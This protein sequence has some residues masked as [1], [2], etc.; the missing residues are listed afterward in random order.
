MNDCNF[1]RAVQ[2][3][4]GLGDEPTAK[5]MWHNL[6]MIALEKQNLRVAQRCFAAL[7]NV[8][9]AF[10]L[11]E[12]INAAEEY[13]RKLSPGKIC[14]E[15]KAKFAL[16]ESDIKTAEKI[17]LENGDIKTAINMYRKLNMWDELI[18]LAERRKHPELQELKE[19]QL[20]YLL[21]TGQEDKA[22]K[23]LENNGEVEKAMSLYLKAKKPTKAA[24]LAMKTPHLFK[25]ENLM[26]QIT[27]AL[28]NA[29]M[30]I[31]CLFIQKKNIDLYY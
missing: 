2:F 31:N 26:T 19:E 13:E 5:A 1:G 29:G 27:E 16:L 7:G 8:S 15:V 4:E 18:N 14:P 30:L 17:Y 6:A 21:S 3:L 23:V 9:K 24:R 11:S 20:N 25:D 10:Y 22:G 28:I 12:M